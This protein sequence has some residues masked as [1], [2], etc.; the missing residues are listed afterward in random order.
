M[1]DQQNLPSMENLQLIDGV[2]NNNSCVEGDE[3]TDIFK[4]GIWK[5][6]YCQDGEY[7]TVPEH[8]MVFN[9]DNPDSMIKTVKGNG[10]DEVGNYSIEGYYSRK[11]LKMG[12]KKQYKLGT[13]DWRYNLGHTVDIHLKW[14]DNLKL[15]QGT[16]YVSTSK[17]DGHG[18][19]Q[20]QFVSS[21]M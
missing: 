4:S 15:F 21:N 6:K 11:T 18:D 7:S 5:G 17:Y 20:L 1:N 13:G 2:S 3:E 8:N 16:W 9:D 10:Y 19:Y 14:N 12:L